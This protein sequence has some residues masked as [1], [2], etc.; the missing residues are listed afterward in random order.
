M[1]IKPQPW[2]T[3]KEIE[4]IAGLIESRQPARVLEWGAGG[5]T[6]YWPVRYPWIDWWTVENNARWAKMIR[7][8]A[9]R[10][11][12][13]L[14]RKPP[15]YC[16]LDPGEVGQFDL[17]IV[18]GSPGQWRVPCL[19]RARR[20]LAPG[21]VVLL[22]DSTNPRHDRGSAFYRDVREF[23]GPDRRGRRGLRI[24]SDPVEIDE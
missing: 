13:L 5:S 22:H 3:K 16:N 8:R 4:A 9:P 6:L 14:E 20:L 1:N 11:V 7:A 18:D 24:F 19:N 21:G 12:T 2:M 17:I 10:T 23:V 15:A